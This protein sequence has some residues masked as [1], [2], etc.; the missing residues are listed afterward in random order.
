M[1][2]DGIVFDPATVAGE[3]I[4]EHGEYQGI[5]TRFLGYLGQARANR[6]MDMGFADV[7]SPR[8]ELVD[9]P[10][11]LQMPRPRLRGYPRESVVAEKLHAVVTLGMINS[12][13]KDL[14]DLW[15]LARK[16]DF[17]GALL[18]KA[19]V[20]T[21]AQREASLPAEMPVGLKDTFAQPKQGQWQAFIQ[22]AKI[23]GAPEVLAEVLGVMREFLWPVLS[24]AAQNRR[25]T[26]QWKAPGPWHSF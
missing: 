21:F 6:Q 14:Y 26:G 10:S 24:A 7:I 4:K 20:G 23:A 22:T 15:L 18:S 25:F 19:I 3:I 1:E 9:D 8:P 5:R 13:M 2:P 16:S 12:R 11:L 17:D